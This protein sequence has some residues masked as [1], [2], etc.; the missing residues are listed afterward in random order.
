MPLFAF[1]KRFAWSKSEVFHFSPFS[2]AFSFLGAATG[3]LVGSQ[4]DI[5]QWIFM[6]TA[7]IFIYIALV[8]MIPELLGDSDASG[9]ILILQA[10]G[11]LLGASIMLTIA[12]YEE[13]FHDL[14][15]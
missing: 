7:G 1:R 14:F 9:R 2:S 6:G 8:D 4:Q 10:S 5:G 12:L 15:E 11:M 3:I 13:T